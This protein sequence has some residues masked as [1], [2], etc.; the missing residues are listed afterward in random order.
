MEMSPLVSDTRCFVLRTKQSEGQTIV[1]LQG[2][3]DVSTASELAKAL[4]RPALTGD[5]VLVDLSAVELADSA[6]LGALVLAQKNVRRRHGELVLAGA[7]G[8]TLRLLEL[9]GLDRAFR[10]VKNHRYA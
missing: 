6:A 3:I 2:R 4:S 5:V 7:T 8:E 9:T 1:E 10:V